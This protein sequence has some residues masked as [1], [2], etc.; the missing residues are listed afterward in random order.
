MSENALLKT[1]PSLLSRIRKR[2]FVPFHAGFIQSSIGVTAFC[3]HILNAKSIDFDLLVQH[4]NRSN[5]S[6]V[7]F[8]GA[9]ITRYGSLPTPQRPLCVVGRLGKGKKK[10]RGPR[11]QGERDDRGLCHITLWQD[12][13]FSVNGG[14]RRRFKGFWVFF[15]KKNWVFLS[16]HRPTRP[17]YFFFDFCFFFIG[18][19]GR[20]F[21]GEESRYSTITMPLSHDVTK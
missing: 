21:C 4:P 13:R 19:R 6:P 12:L 7:T 18:I 9:N 3:V 17:C 16:F 20:S 11:R 10:A 2:S 5:T 1:R 15:K 8:A 14:T